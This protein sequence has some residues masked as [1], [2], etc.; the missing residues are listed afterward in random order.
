MAASRIL[1]VED[2]RIIAED[3]GENLERLGYEVAG[4]EVSGERAIRRAEETEPDLV[5]MDVHIRGEMDGIETAGRIRE[6]LDIPVVYLTAYA[7]E[8]TLQRAKLTGPFGYLVK[9]FNEREMRTTIE[10]A[11][12]KH[13][14]EAELRRAQAQLQRKVEELE[15]RDRLVRFQMSAHSMQEACAEIL[16][17]LARFPGAQRAVI[18][19]PNRAG[20]RLE[21]AAAMGLSE[22]GRL[23]EE[24]GLEGIASFGLEEG[25]EPVA[26]AWHGQQ[27]QV[28]PEGEVAVPILYREEG[29]GVIQIRS[30]EADAEALEALARL[31]GEAALVLQGAEVSEEMA[32][33]GPWLDELQ[34]LE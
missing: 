14:V 23:E 18:L 17:V 33:D 8:K 12:Y 19:R 30:F 31:G 11:L 5:L 27:V 16:Q 7:D 6:K 25:E 34:R 4:T 21:A 9:P 1:I 32:G 20:D 28:G 24:Q 22:P 3:I 2:E 29:L 26:R 15:A 13:G 10:V